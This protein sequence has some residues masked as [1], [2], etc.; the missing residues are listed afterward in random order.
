MQTLQLAPLTA[1]EYEHIRKLVYDLSRINL[2]ANKKELVT[3]RLGKRIRALKLD[4]YRS[5]LAFLDS[6]KGQAELFHL[7]DAIS[8]NHTYFFREE[9]HFEFLSKVALPTL[10]QDK[11][12]RALRLWSAACSS[13]EEAYSLGIHLTQE[14]ERYGWDWKIAC[15]DIST[16]ILE[17]A[18]LGVFAADRLR[19]VTPSM[20]KRFFQKGYGQWEGFFRAAE[21]LRKRLSFARVNLVDASYPWSDQFDIVFLRNVMIYFDR[22]TQEEVVNKIAQQLV[23][24][25]YLIIGQSES[26]TGVKHPYVTCRPSVYQKPS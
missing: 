10:C 4:S 1:R 2:G 8:T 6:P 13:G 14:L 19:G 25:G 26:L 3:A 15:S 9:G 23:P 7:I 16:R 18:Q 17:K 20:Q 11:R 24:G 22:E 5:Y 21:D 12:P